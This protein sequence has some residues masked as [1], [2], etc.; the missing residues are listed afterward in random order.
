MSG[1]EGGSPAALAAAALLATVGCSHSNKNTEKLAMELLK[2]DRANS[3]ELS[4]S[5]SNA[6][7]IRRDAFN[8]ISARPHHPVVGTIPNGKRE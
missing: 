5:K 7:V 3:L 2:Q 4:D 6:R 8:G 1:D